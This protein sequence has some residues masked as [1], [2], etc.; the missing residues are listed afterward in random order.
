MRHVPHLV[1][2]AQPD[3]GT[4][5]VLDDAQVVAVV[6]DVGGELGLIAPADDALLAARRGPPVHFQLQLVRLHQTR[7]VGEPFAEGAQKEQEAVG[8]SLVVVERG[9][10]GGAT[11]AQRGPAR[12]PDRRIRAPRLGV[13]PE[14]QAEAGQGERRGDESHIPSTPLPTR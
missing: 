12:Q 8:F 6:V 4:E 9:V 2:L 3:G 13:D 7:R 1:A 10:G 14:R 5:V 11:A